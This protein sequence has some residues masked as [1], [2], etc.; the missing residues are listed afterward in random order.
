MND[1]EQ[2][3]VE[4]ILIDKVTA[5]LAM[6]DQKMNL[7]LTRLNRSQ[8]KVIRSNKKLDK[9]NKD[10]KRSTLG[11]MFAA[12]RL[13][14]AIQSLLQPVMEAFGVFDLWNSMLTVLFLPVMEALFPL[15]MGVVEFFMNLPE[16]V[17]KLIGA[18]TIFLGVMALLLIAYTTY[19][20]LLAMTAGLQ[21]AV[22]WPIMLIIAALALLIMFWPQISKA[23]VACWNTVVAAFE[24]VWN[25]LVKIFGPI[26]GFFIGIWV[27]VFNLIFSIWTKIIGFFVGIIAG[28]IKIFAPIVKFFSDVFTAAWDAIKLVWNTV[29]EFFG[30]IWDKVKEKFTAMIEWCKGWAS[31]FANAIWDLFPDWL[32]KIINGAISFSAKVVEAAQIGSKTNAKQN[33]FIWRS[34]QGITPISS[35]DNVV[36]VKDLNKLSGNA[37]SGVSNFNP[38][39]NI[40]VIDK[41]WVMQI[42]D[43]N[44]RKM[45]AEIRRNSV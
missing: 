30:A 43:E 1:S 29:A 8:D 11:G 7:A 5:K 10:I 41:S 44:N 21:M 37:S 6:I 28:I 19:N 32:K 24:W 38:V 27:G 16:P 33:D 18:L 25:M 35:Q 39:Y 40:N 15:F 45:L 13:K 31:K 9:T 12:Y 3:M 2:V 20:T 36:G 26:V 4:M 22:L 34:G 14:G 23:A 42:I 17:Q